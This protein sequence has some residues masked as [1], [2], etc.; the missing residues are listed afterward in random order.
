LGE[1]VNHQ[2][3]RGGAVKGIDDEWGVMGWPLNVELSTA[4]AWIQNHNP[5][6]MGLPFIGEECYDPIPISPIE[7]PDGGTIED[8]F[9]R[10]NMLSSLAESEDNIRLTVAGEGLVDWMEH[11][12]EISVFPF[13]GNG[14]LGDPYVY[15]PLHFLR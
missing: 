15:S 7:P 10:G 11:A 1:I 12:M 9:P 6:S 14:D 3:F 13:N 2:E 8:P 5:L 4:Q